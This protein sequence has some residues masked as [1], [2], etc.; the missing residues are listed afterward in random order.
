[1]YTFLH[2]LVFEPIELLIFFIKETKWT[3]D[4]EVN[5]SRLSSR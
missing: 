3:E 5:T 2:S 4:V 1:M